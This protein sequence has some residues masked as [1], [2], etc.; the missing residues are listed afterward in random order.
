MLEICIIAPGGQTVRKVPL[1]EGRPVR[2]G[3]AQ[4]AEIRLDDPM[5]SRNHAVIVPGNT[6]QW[7]LRDAGSTHGCFIDGQR[8]TETPLKHGTEIR[9]GGAI[10]RVDDVTS[11]VAR[12][13]DRILDDDDRQ[14]GPVEVEIIGLDGRRSAHLDDTV[15]PTTEGEKPHI[16]SLVRGIRWPGTRSNK[17]R[18]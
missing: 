8:I 14:G 12:E 17:D 1:P 2:V 13:L 10:L 15:A 6:G 7:M 3:R 16:A 4:D 11:R 5:V 18:A 9:I